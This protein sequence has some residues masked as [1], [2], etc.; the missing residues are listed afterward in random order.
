MSKK[1]HK[2]AI[3][4]PGGVKLPQWVI[5]IIDFRNKS[6]ELDYELTSYDLEE[7]D[8]KYDKIDEAISKMVEIYTP[9]YNNTGPTGFSEVV[10]IDV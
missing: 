2:G 1:G 4:L 10:I 8:K 7:V 5:T 9:H 3:G 6:I